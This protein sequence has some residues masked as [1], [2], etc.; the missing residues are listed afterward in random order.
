MQW[1]DVAARSGAGVRGAFG[2]TR[3]GLLAATTPGRTR[4][5]FALL[6]VLL[7]AAW[8]VE[9]GIV[10]VREGDV[11]V[12]VDNL[13]GRSEVADAVGYRFVFPVIQSFYRLDRKIQSLVMAD[14]P[15]AGFRGGDAVKLKT[16][17]GSDVS[18]DVLVSY[19]L[20]ASGAAEILRDAGDGL[21][22]ADLWVRSSVRAV[23]ARSFGELTAE[24]I[25]NAGE[26]NAKATDMLKTLNRELA[27]QHIEVLAITPRDVRFFSAYEEI[28]KKKKIKDQETQQYLSE[29]RL[30]E[31]RQRTEVAQAEFEAKQ[32][33][34][35]A[36]GEADKVRAEADGYAKRVAIE[37]DGELAKAL[38][39]AEGQL[40]IGLAEAEGIKEQA[41]A[42]GG[43]GGVNLVALAY[44]KKLAT[45]SISGIPVL[46]DPTQGNVRV[47]QIGAIQ[48]SPQT[49]AAPPQGPELPP[50]I[51]APP[52]G[53]R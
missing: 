5:V 27:P 31:Q 4:R 12:I 51:G 37:A 7:L 3:R 49:N 6:V 2:A 50:G 26:R 53:K 35:R 10:R 33:V 48:S 43:A 23:V 14:A 24:S 30:A 18:I 16:K 9:E 17:D 29:A 42:L 25:Y 34:Q 22:F 39:E 21:R 8:F 15:E 19:H 28:I 52:G 41:A 46:Q 1:K 40:A 47:Q 44:A 45:F 36:E 38:K 13:S 20:I 11:G 32:T